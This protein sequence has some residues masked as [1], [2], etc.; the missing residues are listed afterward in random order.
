MIPIKTAPAL[1]QAITST[2]IY[3]IIVALAF[4]LILFIIANLIKWK[5]GSNDNSG[6]VRRTWYFI[7]AV[8]AILTSVGLDYFF[9]LTSIKVPAFV[10]KYAMH[11][12]IASILSGVLYAA[13]SF[14][15]I[16][17]SRIGSKMESIFP[18]KD[19]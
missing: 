19:R 6:S 16:K 4:V 10:G 11:I 7:L 15:V 2:Y 18:K 17:V 3:D 14:V 13:I 5:S 1:Q 9:F 8:A 12:G